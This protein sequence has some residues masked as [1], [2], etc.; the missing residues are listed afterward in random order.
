M[1]NCDAKGE[2]C[3]AADLVDEED[4]IAV[5]CRDN[6]LKGEWAYSAVRALCAGHLTLLVTTTAEEFEAFCKS[7]PETGDPI[8]QNPWKVKVLRA[9]LLRVGA[10]LD[11]PLAREE[12]T[13]PEP[14]E[15]AVSWFGAP[16]NGVQV[17]LNGGDQPSEQMEL[18]ENA[19]RKPSWSPFGQPVLLNGV[20]DAPAATT[21]AAS[22]PGA[23]AADVDSGLHDCDLEEIDTTDETDP[24]AQPPTAHQP[25]WSSVTLVLEDHLE[26]HLGENGNEDSEGG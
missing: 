5:W 13:D 18:P 6:D 8:G 4:E 12:P 9:A 11:V 17:Q 10:P 20:D 22:A 26:D 23:A 3:C 15:P 16:F 1:G 24:K 7:F 25:R 21:N 2:S 19:V 14:P